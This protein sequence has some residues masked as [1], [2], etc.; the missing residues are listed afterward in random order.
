MTTPEEL[1]AFDIVRTICADSAL[2]TPVVSRDTSGWFTISAGSPR[3]WFARLYFNQKRRSIT[4]KIA[5]ARAIPL[6]PGFEVEAFQ[7]GSRVYITANKDIH[8]LRPLLL[9]AFEEEVKRKEAP[10]DDSEP[11]TGAG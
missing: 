11:A 9:L 2:K 4:T 1:E 3:K 10:G 6:A 5:H 7:E 8:R